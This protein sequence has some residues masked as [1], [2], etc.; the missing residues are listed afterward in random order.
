MDEIPYVQVF[1]LLYQNK[2][3]QMKCK[4]MIHQGGKPGKSEENSRRTKVT[5]YYSSLRFQQPWP[6]HCPLAVRQ[7][8]KEL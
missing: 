1:M 2:P 4:I 6:F 7:L 8:E 5:Y 3:I